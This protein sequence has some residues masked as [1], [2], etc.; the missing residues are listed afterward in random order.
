MDLKI[1]WDVMLNKLNLFWQNYKVV[2]IVT[3]TTG[4]L[5]LRKILD[6]VRRKWYNL[7]PGPAGLPF[8]GDLFSLYNPMHGIESAKKYGPIHLTHVGFTQIC[9]ISDHSLLK[10]YYSSKEFLERDV[11][12]VGFEKTLAEI[13]LRDNWHDRRKIMKKNVVSQLNSKILVSLIKTTMKKYIFTEIDKCIKK[14]IKWDVR[15]ECN[16]ITFATIYGSS[17]GDPCPTPNDELFLQFNNIN[18]QL[19]EAMPKYVLYTILFPKI[20]FMTKVGSKLSGYQWCMKQEF[21]IIKQWC[22]K[23]DSKH[24]DHKNDDAYDKK[25]SDLYYPS[26]KHSIEN[27]KNC[28]IT[29]DQG[30]ADIVI[31][32]SGGMHTT[33]TA[34]EQS[35]LY[36]AKCGIEIQ[37]E[38]YD[39]LTNVVNGNFDEILSK[40]YE[41]KVLSSFINEIIR[42][43]GFIRTGLPRT[44]VKNNVKIELSSNKFYTIPKGTTVFS[45]LNGINHNKQYWENELN[46]SDTLIFDPKR[47]VDEKTGELRRKTQLSTFGAGRRSCPGQELAMRELYL[48]IS[49]LVWNYQFDIPQTCQSKEDFVVPILFEDPNTPMVGVKVVK[50]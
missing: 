41:L 6:I 12:P 30:I 5:T 32:F 35:V 47:F 2:R 23:Y 26:L 16:F 13:P 17:F 8:F 34:L 40:R 33:S 37:N 43:H 10:K 28:K 15:K 25:N 50:R 29:M 3:Y 42:K 14:N 46:T 24:Y 7:P 20:D 18:N 38:I 19:F 22:E 44:I 9:I 49:M 11:G 45:S 21:N 36:L 1:E 39:E 48:V 31:S 27:D 4:I